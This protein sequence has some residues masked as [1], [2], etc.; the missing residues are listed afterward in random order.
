MGPILALLLI[1]GILAAP[2]TTAAVLDA[3]IT[4]LS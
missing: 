2:S 3:L 1:G 4:L